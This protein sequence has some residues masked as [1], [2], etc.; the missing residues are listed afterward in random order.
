MSLRQTKLHFPCRTCNTA[1][2]Q[3]MY[4][5]HVPS[6][7]PSFQYTDTLE[8]NHIPQSLLIGTPSLDN[9]QPVH[10]LHHRQTCTPYRCRRRGCNPCY[11]CASLNPHDSLVADCQP[12]EYSEELGRSGCTCGCRCVRRCVVGASALH[13]CTHIH[14]PCLT[15]QKS[16]VE[17]G[18]RVWLVHQLCTSAHTYTHLA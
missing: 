8:K 10:R 2:A 6:S 14:T 3:L 9:R 1:H 11:V 12:I 4:L 13:I 15:A 17:V 18:A 5:P 16:W 7:C